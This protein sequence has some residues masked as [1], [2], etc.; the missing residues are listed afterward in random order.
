VLPCRH[1]LFALTGAFK[2]IGS[3]I[4]IVC[5]SADLQRSAGAG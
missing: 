1:K 3:R 5:A 4:A 2:Q